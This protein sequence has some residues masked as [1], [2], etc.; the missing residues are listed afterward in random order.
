MR[1]KRELDVGKSQ[2]TLP[3]GERYQ[4]YHLNYDFLD[5]CMELHNFPKIASY[6]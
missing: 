4:Y 3:L 1:A 6:S 2:G 5:I